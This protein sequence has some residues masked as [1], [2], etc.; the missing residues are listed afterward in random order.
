MLTK[1]GGEG[2][3]D[4]LAAPSALD[5][6]PGGGDK[7]LVMRGTGSGVRGRSSAASSSRRMD[8]ESFCLLRASPRVG[9]LVD[10]WWPSKGVDQARG[11]ESVPALYLG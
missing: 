8:R 5:V 11:V 6:L 10:P 9:S 7:R 4:R 1:R 3:S 2:G